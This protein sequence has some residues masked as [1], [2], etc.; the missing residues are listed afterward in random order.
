MGSLE[1]V[2]VAR[3]TCCCVAVVSIEGNDVASFAMEVEVDHGAEL[4][5]S[6]GLVL[7]PGVRQLDPEPAV[8][9]AMLEGWVRQQHSR[10]LRDTTVSERVRMIR[11]F[12][13]FTGQYPWQWQPAEVEAFTA[14]LR[15]RVRDRWRF[16]LCGPTRPRCDCSSS[17][18]PIHGM[19]GCGSA[20]HGSVWCRR[21]PAT[22]GTR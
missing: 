15:A 2:V 5:G 3:L 16:R 14:D 11:R 20:R 13:G 22:S 12:A 18:L 10:M 19:A 21:R 17:T 8:F 7:P 6:A 9:S 1:R 4:A